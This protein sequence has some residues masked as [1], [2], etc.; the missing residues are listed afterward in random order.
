MVNTVIMGQGYVG[1][2]L[3]QGLANTGTQKSVLGF[4]V[5][6]RVVNNLN[7]GISHID[8]ISN[9]EVSEIIAKGYRATCTPAD[10]AT[11]DTVVIC[12]PTPLYETGEPDL[13]YVESAVQL[14]ADNMSPGTL[15]V[16]E[17]TTYP[18]TTEDLVRPMLEKGG[19][20]LDKDFY[21]AFSPERIDPGNKQYKIT[22]TPKIVGG[23]SAESTKR[24]LAFYTQFIETVIETVGTR[25]AETAKLLENTYRHVNIALMNEMAMFCHELGI[26]VW[27]VVRLASSKPYGF[28][29][30]Y[31]GPGVGGHCIPVDPNYLS[32]EVKRRLGVPFRFIEMATD[33][34]TGMP[35]YVV[36]RIQDLLNDQSKALKG[37]RVLLLGV[38]YKPD[39]ADL[40]ESPALEVAELLLDKGADM[41]FHD[42]HATQFRVHGEMLQ[43]Q[44]DLDAAL[45]AADVV[46]LL[47]A[48]KAYDL[49]DIASKSKVIFDTRGKLSGANV[50]R[51]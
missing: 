3:A 43:G 36:G 41:V 23:S 13:S 6:E 12:V 5:S 33:I 46:V 18:G 10:I 22:N 21:L 19:R 42:P 28:Q 8:D 15:V 47:Q 49:E 51:L 20:E 24:A 34:N 45:A 40:R 4:D 29:A 16:L 31:P 50:E 30:F 44:T 7:N 35:N 9:A 37:S 32:Y 38:T 27:E 26:D 39:I 17:S 2:P 1:L 25:E 48:H 11:A 14:I